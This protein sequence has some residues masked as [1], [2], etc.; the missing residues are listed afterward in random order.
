MANANPTGA[1]RL[2]IAPSARK[3]ERCEAD[4][5]HWSCAKRAV[6]VVSEWMTGGSC[7]KIRK[8][9]RSKWFFQPRPDSIEYVYAG[10]GIYAA[11][12][13]YCTVEQKKL[14]EGLKH[15][16]PKKQIEMM[17]DAGEK[18]RCGNCG[19]QAAM[20]FRYL[21]QHGC[22]SIEYVQRKSADPL[23]EGHAF[24]VIDRVR[25]SSIEYPSTWGPDAIIC[26]A[27]NEQ[28]YSVLDMDVANQ[29]KQRRELEVIFSIRED[30]PVN[31]QEDRQEDHAKEAAP[32]DYP[33]PQ[34]DVRYA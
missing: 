29:L 27:W 31:R 3:D 23:D 18:L 5:S 26:D 20:A 17:A 10:C 6:N 15:E 16:S 1:A 34:M 24:V 22:Q 32:G 25:G 28:V 12:P 7:T 21:A 2:Q 33:M 19:V 8:E 30:R 11:K 9:D 14:L 4:S 13:C